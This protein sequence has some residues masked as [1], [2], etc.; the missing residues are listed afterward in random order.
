METS[1]G[2]GF[3]NEKFCATQGAERSLFL[4]KERS[5]CFAFHFSHKYTQKPFWFPVFIYLKPDINNLAK[6][7]TNPHQKSILC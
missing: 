3:K 1:E 5:G 4:K 6:I 7:C 2:F